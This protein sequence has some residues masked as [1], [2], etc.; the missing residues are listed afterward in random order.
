MWVENAK[1]K[2]T[3][4]CSN[5]NVQIK[6]ESPYSF[7]VVSKRASI[8]DLESENVLLTT[9]R[10]RH[11]GLPHAV[12]EYDGD[13]LIFNTINGAQRITNSQLSFYGN[14]MDG[15]FTL[16][17]LAPINS[18]SGGIMNYSLTRDVYY[19]N[20]TII[21]AKFITNGF[22]VFVKNTL[23]MDGSSTISNNGNDA[24]FSTRGLGASR[25]TIGGGGNGSDGG[26]NSNLNTFVGVMGQSMSNSI[27]GFGGNGCSP[28]DLV[29]G[30]T[31]GL[32]SQ[33][34]P[35]EGGAEIIN[36]PTA[37]I[38]LRTI[39]SNTTIKGGGGGGSGGGKLSSNGLV[40]TRGGGGG[41]GGMVLLIARFIRCLTTQCL[42]DAHGGNGGDAIIN[43]T[44]IPSDLYNLQSATPFSVLAFSTV[45]NTGNS[46]IDGDLG[47]YPGTSIT[48][49]P[50]GVLSGN[51]YVANSTAQTARLEA[52]SLYNTLIAEPS[53][54]SL[55]GQNLGGLTLT[56]GVYSFSSAAAL[57]GILTLDGQSNPNSF[58]IFKIG[59]MLTTSVNS[60]ITLSNVLN[61]SNIFW[62]LGSSGTIGVSSTFVGTIIA[63]S[64]ITIN[65]G[66]T[67]HGRAIALNGAVT[68]DSNHFLQNVSIDPGFG[69]DFAG[70]GGGGGGGAIVVCSEKIT[71]ILS[72]NVSGGASGAS[73]GLMGQNTIQASG[74]RIV[75]HGI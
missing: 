25:G 30:G 39:D 13:T 52:N 43:G 4:L 35:F 19:D 48:G 69:Y 18:P 12:L 72:K 66:A 11:P 34:L 57:T 32:A 10:F 49:F 60:I 63:Q 26:T 47:L 23:T 50:P 71:G 55:T 40:I 21:N 54:T 7:S 14:G 16:G 22:R 58:W 15:D 51:Q 29:I 42:I 1:I 17:S 62:L 37:C 70:G 8:Y 56:S 46:D 24:V 28:S 3:I 68:L 44:I 59:S 65:T 53:T 67:I 41:G 38:S 20:L 2:Y 73:I 6:M 45:T 31:G 61:T 64:S 36:L 9:L 74:G 5:F 33:P 27:G 75:D